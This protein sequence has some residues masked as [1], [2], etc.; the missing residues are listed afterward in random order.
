MSSGGVLDLTVVV[1]TLTLFSV[2]WPT[3]HLTHEVPAPL[4]PIVAGCA[5]LPF[6]L[7]RVNPDLGWLISAGA[8]LTI[9]W[10]FDVHA[11]YPLPWQVVHIIV[12]LVLLAAVVL[13]CPPVHAGLAWLGTVLLFI[14]YAPGRDGF[15]WAFGLTALA[16]FCV[17]I[18]WLVLSRRQ[19][20]RQEELSE[21]ERTRRTV[22][23]E[24][25]RIARD[26]HDVVAHHMSLVVVQAQTAPYRLSDVSPEARAEFDSI[27]E[28]AR[29]ALNEIRGMLGVLRSDGQSAELAPQPGVGQLSALFDSSR[30]AGVSLTPVV[31]G[32]QDGVTEAVGLAAYRIVQESLANAARHA[33]GAAVEARVDLGAAE[34]ELVVVTVVNGPV[35]NGPVVNAPGAMGSGGNGIAGMRERAQS[36]G[37]TLEAHPLAGG[38][39]AVSARLPRTGFAVGSA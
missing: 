18:R 1:T 21:L 14:G 35:A 3:L 26:L 30:R 5:A 38:G 13:R 17:L 15:G 6:A 12:L 4:Q 29:Q 23:E 20:A 8:A 27:G 10:F 25:A 24:R 28:V 19:L 7:I 9:P 16:L 22:L 34:S 37:G 33:P 39:F 31:S 36:V 11:D 32:E 2:A